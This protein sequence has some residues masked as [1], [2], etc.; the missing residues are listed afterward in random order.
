[1]KVCAPPRMC[2]GVSAL[3]RVRACAQPLDSKGSRPCENRACARGWDRH[4][5]HIELPQPHPE[6]LH[7]RQRLTITDYALTLGRPPPYP[8]RGLVKQVRDNIASVFLVPFLSSKK[9]PK[10]KQNKTKNTGSIPRFK[11]PVVT[12]KG[13][14]QRSRTTTDNTPTLPAVPARQ[15][16]CSRK[17][18]LRLNAEISAQRLMGAS[19]IFLS[20]T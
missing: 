11:G 14:S 8:K 17:M 2:G 20:S 3:R 1:M 13:V 4:W 15:T 18:A 16:V 6:L 10:M 7:Q 9:N 19:L 12:Q 5:L